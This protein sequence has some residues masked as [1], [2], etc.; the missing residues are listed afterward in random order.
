MAVPSILTLKYKEILPFQPDHLGVL[1]IFRSPSHLFRSFLVGKYPGKSS[2][3]FGFLDPKKILGPPFF[4]CPN[5]PLFK[6]WV[7]RS[8][9]P[10]GVFLGE[11]TS[12]PNQN[13]CLENK[14]KQE[15]PNF[16]LLAVQKKQNQTIFCEQIQ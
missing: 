13:K 1:L 14:K 9:V 16:S 4:T 6:T 5:P 8:L 15:N 7:F 10:G 12:N 11:K 3:K 2:W